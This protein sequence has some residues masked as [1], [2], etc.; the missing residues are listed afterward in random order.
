MNKF[1]L[2]LTFLVSSLCL[3]DVNAETKGHLR[4]DIITVADEF[5]KG[6]QKLNKQALLYHPTAKKTE[7]SSLVIYLHGSGGSNKSISSMKWK[8]DS[9]HLLSSDQAQ[10]NAKIL[11]PQS[12]KG[13]EPDELNKM[14]DYILKANPEIDPKRVYCIGFSMGGKGTWNWASH[15]PERFAAI[16]PMGFIPDYE[17]LNKMVTL[18]IWAMVGSKD[19]RPRVQ[20]V[21]EM[22]KKLEEL[23]SK[24]VKISVFEG[25]KHNGTADKGFAVDGLMTWLFSQKR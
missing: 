11:V 13:W 14:L 7:Q 3:F 18:P 21:P 17:N 16:I 20:G 15:S 8:G 19:S 12:K 23:G 25:V 22:G 9:K 24:V 5:S 10:Y 6:F 1:Q 4:L 2:L